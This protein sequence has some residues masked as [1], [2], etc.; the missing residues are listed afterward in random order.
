VTV[1]SAVNSTVVVTGRDGA[2]ALQPGVQVAALW[3]NGSIQAYA[4]TNASGQ[5]TFSLPDN[6]YRFDVQEDYRTNPPLIRAIRAATTYGEGARGNRRL[7][8]VIA[9]YRAPTVRPR[10]PEH[11]RVLKAVDRGPSLRPSCR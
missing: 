3:N 10:A 8:R 5:A 11:S 6:T 7:A 9:T 1:R 2:G 4:D